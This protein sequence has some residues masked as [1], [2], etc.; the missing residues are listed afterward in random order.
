MD[1]NKTSRR[2]HDGGA[3]HK[4]AL[5]DFFKAKRDAKR[6]GSIGDGEVS[7]ELR[8]IE[9]AAQA[10]ADQ[11]AAI[12]G[13]A[14][15]TVAAAA[16]VTGLPPP[17]PPPPP[18][19]RLPPPPPPRGNILRPPPP[20][21]PR[22]EGE[23]GYRKDE[24]EEEGGREGGREGEEVG[25]PEGRYS[26][27]GVTYL[28]GKHFP[29]KMVRGTRCEVWVEGRDEWREGRVVRVQVTAVPNTTLV[30]RKFA[31]AFVKKKKE[32]EEEEEEEGGKGGGV[33]KEEG[34]VG[35]VKKEEEVV[36]EGVK[37]EEGKEE[38]EEEEEEI[39]EDIKPDRLRMVEALLPGNVGAAPPFLPP[40]P[41][42]P[43]D[44]DTG[45]GGWQTVSVR[46]FD[47]EAERRASLKAIK[48][49]TKK[50][51]KEDAEKR[52]K[53]IE[54]A[55]EG[56]DALSSYDPHNRGMYKGIDLNAAARGGE[57]GVL[58]GEVGG[59]AVEVDLGGDR[60]GP[61]AFKKKKKEGG[62]GGG[63]GAKFRRRTSG[64]DDD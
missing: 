8:A 18:P 19:P 30:L 40:P 25:E 46:T 5:D 23:G 58:L 32:E 42:P 55:M 27:D 17:P 9:K 14:T 22:R 11:D 7:K 2:L 21:P 48:A 53:M 29:E 31:V 43:V 12:F 51:K 63:G 20:P 50:R 28:E 57:G 49:E 39:E 36:G 3:R 6:Q 33:K 47:E 61:V 38:E 59:A 41:P 4:Q 52:S 62:G 13:G 37:K 35:G 10:Q 56:E 34:V 54:E 1:D 45:L 24:D 15:A 44:T 16:A 26:V 64:D 60:D